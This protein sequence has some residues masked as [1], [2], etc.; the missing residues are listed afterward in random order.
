VSYSEEFKQEINQVKALFYSSDIDSGLNKLVNIVNHLDWNDS[1]LP[2]YVFKELFHLASHFLKNEKFILNVKVLI[3][4]HKA[5][6][7]K[8]LENQF[9]EPLGNLEGFVALSYLESNDIENYNKWSLISCN[10]FLTSAELFFKDSKYHQSEQFYKFAYDIVKDLELK[11]NSLPLELKSLEGLILAKTE[12]Y[13]D[14]TTIANYYFYSNLFNEAKKFA[15]KALMVSMDIISRIV[16]FQLIIQKS[17]KTIKQFQLKN[18]IEEIL[19]C[20]FLCKRAILS[21]EDEKKPVIE[22]K[23]IELQKF[24]EDI[25]DDEPDK[26]QDVEIWLE[27][28]IDSLKFIIPQSPSQYMF[29]T[30]DGRLIHYHDPLLPDNEIT[31]SAHKHLVAGVLTA[32]TSMFFE[33][34]FLGSG[35]LN[36]INTVDHTLIIENRPNI[37]V[38]GICQIALIEEII[39][40]RKL[41]DLLEE[42]YGSLLTNWLGNKSALK[43]FITEIKEYL[44]INQNER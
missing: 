40:T 11:E 29:L 36:Q 32:I 23:L 3:E 30:T 10:S 43:E 41:A 8:L 33:H 26:F 16:K 18:V 35:V 27:T 24:F 14:L 7:N 17:P 38:I 15:W 12:N 13:K 19:D 1:Q 4:L 5:L 21:V 42:K 25:M 22:L 39:I 9:I 34:N 20:I 31:D 44:T 37:V 2:Q 6:K 28:Q